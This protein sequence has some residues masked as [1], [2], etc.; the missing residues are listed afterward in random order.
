MAHPVEF[1]LEIHFRLNV[2]I[3]DKDGA[4]TNVTRVGSREVSCAPH[5]H[6]FLML[7]RPE[8]LLCRDPP[9]NCSVLGK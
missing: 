6:R 9:S 1:K 4:R 8:E 3:V 2:D 5:L 7:W